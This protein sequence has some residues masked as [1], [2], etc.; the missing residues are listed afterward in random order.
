MS[1][2]NRHTMILAG[3]VG[4]TKTLIGLFQFDQRRPV[5]V[6]IRSFATTEFDGLP[7]IIERFYAAQPTRPQV[8]AAAFGVAGPVIQQRAQMTNVPWS[9][10]AAELT[11]TFGVARVHLLNDLESM[12]TS[13]PILAPDEL[14]SLQ[15]G[16]NDPHGSIGL[17]AAGT[18]LGQS[19]LHHVAGRY[20]PLAS[21]G[22]H[23]DFA[24]RSDREIELVRFLRGRY[25]RAELEHVLSGRGLVNLSDFTHQAGD[26][27]LDS[28][29]TPDRPAEVT[30][31]GLAGSCPLC[32]EALD[33]FVSAYGATA[34]N[35]GLAA[36]TTG[37]IFIGGG[38][39]PKI[40]PALESGRFLD[41][42]TDKGPMR[43]LLE[44]MPVSVI[45][46]P[47]AA[48]LGAAAYANGMR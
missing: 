45:L 26:C 25:G 43:P 11:R 48:L 7:A 47:E 1:I 31:A 17:I 19:V 35:L 14:K 5:P 41:A 6:D 9:V 13:L 27:T 44:A 22:G 36:M 3:D 39:G 37:G 29:G 2:Y 18:G 40:L 20:V 4:G 46:N 30:A 38:I 34:G 32:V 24:A 16:V 28:S 21:E 12:A 42:F 15:P 23:M 8:R 10:D 33:L